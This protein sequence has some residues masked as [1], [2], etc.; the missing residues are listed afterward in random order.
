MK[1]VLFLFADVA[2]VVGGVIGAGFA[3]GEEVSLYFYGKN[4][5]LSSLAAFFVFFAV[6]YIFLSIGRKF[7][8]LE[9][10]G[11]GLLDS[12]ISLMTKASRF[13]LN[14]NYFAVLCS[15]LAGA[16]VTLSALFAT[17]TVHFVFGAATAV[18]CGLILFFDMKGIR[19]FSDFVV[20]FIVLLIVIVCLMNTE[21]GTVQGRGGTGSALMYV[22]MNCVIMSGILMGLGGTRSVNG[23]WLSL[24]SALVLSVLLYLIILRVNALERAVTMPL[25]YYAYL[26]GSEIGALMSVVVYFSIVTTVIACAY[27]LV[28]W[29]T[30]LLKSKIL[31]IAAVFCSALAVSLVGFSGIVSYVY[32]VISVLG[33]LVIITYAAF[34]IYLK[35]SAAKKRRAL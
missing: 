7:A 15:M 25:L 21:Y 4:A 2:V 19:R 28:E 30:P 31:A 14:F 20:P 29:L 16:N 32:P 11:T 8:E 13:L 26:I 12:R 24:T 3:S 6:F 22:S 10:C 9:K 18:V 35:L 34:L 23:F 5:L 27:P 17:H 1:K 33:A